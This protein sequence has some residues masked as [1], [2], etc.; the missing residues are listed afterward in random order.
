VGYVN[1][2]WAEYTY[3]T[4]FQMPLWNTMFK[5]VYGNDTPTIRSN[6]LGESK[7][8]VVA[9]TMVEHD[10]FQANVRYRLEQA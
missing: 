10:E 3:N 1:R 9:K 4:M 6:D 5:L 8:V 2:Q 7:V